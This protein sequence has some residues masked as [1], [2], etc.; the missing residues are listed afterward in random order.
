MPRDSET[1]SNGARPLQRAVA[2][3]MRPVEY[4]AVLRRLA[5]ERHEAAG[6]FP[7]I[8]SF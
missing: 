2:L 3:P 4:A 8:R 1:Y 6:D 7:E 5:G